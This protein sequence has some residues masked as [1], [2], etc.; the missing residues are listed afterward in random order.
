MFRFALLLLMLATPA[1]A[2]TTTWEIDP[3]HSGAHFAV[4]HLMIAKVRGDLGK[5]TGTVVLDD[6]DITQSRV[7]A[8]ID[9]TGIDTREAKRDEHL[10]SPDFFD[11]AKYPTITFVSKRV[12]AGADGQ[13]KVTG[14]LTLHGVTKEVVLDVEGATTP[15]QDAFGNTKLG[16]TVTTRLNRQDFGISYGGTSGAM[17]GNEVD[18][19]VDIELIKK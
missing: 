1:F 12:E 2:G 10:K 11:V 13:Y 18:V 3:A 9:V 19:I 16:G 15:I 7:E 14:D 5:I 17:I 8:T 4:R 6:A